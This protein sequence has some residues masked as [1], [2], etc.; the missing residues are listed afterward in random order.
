[1]KNKKI[2]SYINYLNTELDNMA[3]QEIKEE[4]AC[5][6]EIF[7][8]PDSIYHIEANKIS[9]LIVEKQEAYG[10]AFGKSGDIIKILYPNGIPLS[11]INDALT[12]IRMLDKL[13]RIATNKDALGEDPFK[14]IAG[15]ALL[16]VVRNND[17]KPLNKE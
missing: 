13:F 5:Y 16:A 6:K 9:D 11:K 15:Y 7:D 12:V 10:N 17:N 1:M 2:K 14:D 3:R 8:I 4:L